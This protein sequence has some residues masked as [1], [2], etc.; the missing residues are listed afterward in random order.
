[1]QQCRRGWVAVVDDVTLTGHLF[2]HLGDDSGVR[3]EPYARADQRDG[4]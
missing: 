1:M 2:I 4:R 3:A